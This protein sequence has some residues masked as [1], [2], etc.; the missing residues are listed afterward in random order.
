MSLVAINAKIFGILG[1]LW[2]CE[3]VL[4]ELQVMWD[5]ITVL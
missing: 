1:T 4:A 2:D 5:I 3:Q